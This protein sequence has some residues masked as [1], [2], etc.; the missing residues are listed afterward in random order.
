MCVGGGGGGGV[1]VSVVYVSVVC[2]CVSVV[3]VC[4]C[5][6]CVI[7]FPINDGRSHS[8]SM[9]VRRLVLIECIENGY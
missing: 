4:V 3:C 5:R 9:Y 8:C 6:V 1:C 2:V 7:L